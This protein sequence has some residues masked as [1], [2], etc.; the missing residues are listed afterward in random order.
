M[1]NNNLCN[2]KDNSVI[3]KYGILQSFPTWQKERLTNINEY[4]L[5]DRAFVAHLAGADHSIRD[6]F[7]TNYLKHNFPN[8]CKCGFKTQTGKPACCVLCHNNVGHG[9]LCTKQ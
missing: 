8:L 4:G 1:Y 7:S 5:S 3:I 6:F 9:H 2:L